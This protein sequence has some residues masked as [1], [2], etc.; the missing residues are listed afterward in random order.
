MNTLHRLAVLVDSCLLPSVR[1]GAPELPE[2][3]LRGLE[4]GTPGVAVH[5]DGTAARAASDAV[6]A[7]VPDA[8]TG[9]PGPR[10]GTQNGTQNGSAAA[11]ELMAVGANLHL[12]V[13]PDPRADGTRDFVSD[14]QAHGVAAALGPFTGSGNLRPFA[15]AAAAGVRAI[16]AGVP[17]TVSGHTISGVLRGE[18]GYSG[19]VL[20]APLDE[21]T[22][23][24]GWGAPGAAV[25]AWIA[26]ADLIRLGPGSGPGVRDAIHAA[27][28]RAV[29]DGDLPVAR[30]EEAAARVS[31]LRRWASEPCLVPS[32]AGSPLDRPRAADEHRPAAR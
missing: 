24:D 16:S 4:R 12:G 30:L 11:A 26:G 6:R 23:V 17:A 13:G 21:P 25:L 3:I 20:S 5:A 1:G 29:G 28:A 15:E 18:L 32:S 31:R 7:A 22:I 9:H 19:V 8:L 2:W 10:G 27:T 14:L